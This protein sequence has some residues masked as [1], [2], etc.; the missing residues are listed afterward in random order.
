MSDSTVT[1]IK[2]CERLLIATEVSTI[3]RKP[4]RWVNSEIKA[5]YLKG[6]KLGA[7]KWY[8]HPR[9]LEAY[10]RAAEKGVLGYSNLKPSGGR[11]MAE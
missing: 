7:N 2:G 10:I 5:G 4:V 3:L 8:V 6:F 9:S 11:R 1:M